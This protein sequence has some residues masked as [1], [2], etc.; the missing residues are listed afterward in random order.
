M[1]RCAWCGM[2]QEG[3]IS[4][5]R[6]INKFCNNVCSRAYRAKYGIPSAVGKKPSKEAREKM[7]KNHADRRGDKNP[8]WKGGVTYDKR[9][10][11]M[12][13]IKGYHSADKD[14][15]VYEHR[16]LEEQRL[17]RP[18]GKYERVQIKKNNT[19]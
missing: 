6:S 15:Y 14:G 16:Y 3:F 11:K 9:G 10:V 4:E 19:I 17:G 5:K 2:L 8:A 7:R 1:Y 18:L 13:M 12:I